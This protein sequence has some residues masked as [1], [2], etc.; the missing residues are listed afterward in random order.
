MPTTHI[1]YPKIYHVPKSPGITRDDKVL[2]E[3]EFA[4]LCSLPEIVVTEKMDGE[5]T[6]MYS[7]YIHA[8]SVE[9]AS[10]PSRSKIRALHA[11]I[12]NDIPEG[13]RICGENLT[14]VHSIF[15]DS[16]PAI[17]LVFNVWN[18]HNVCLS[19][20]DTCEYAKLLGLFTVPMLYRGSGISLSEK[21]DELIATTDFD[22]HEGFVIRNAGAFPYETFQTNI[23]KYVRAGHV[24]TDAHWKY[25]TV[26]YNTI[27]ETSLISKGDKNG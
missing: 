16:L 26:K 17:F 22:K 24:Q 25:Q 21:L 5:N 13:W 6:T 2:S 15:Y 20:D 11:A 10:H 23:A 14:A 4:N 7:D 12:A 27:V 9:Y 3:I 1:K 8:R 18:E 19:W